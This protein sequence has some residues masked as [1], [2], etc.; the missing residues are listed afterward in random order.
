[1]KVDYVQVWRP[2][3]Q[4]LRA[5]VHYRHWKTMTFIAALRCGRINAPF[6]FDQPNNTISFT[7]WVEQ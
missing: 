4:R 7:A 2:I 1:M 5:K 6:V 3:G